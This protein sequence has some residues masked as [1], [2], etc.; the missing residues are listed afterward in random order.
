M[1]GQTALLSV[2]VMWIPTFGVINF[3]SWA[4]HEFETLPRLLRKFLKEFHK[5]EVCVHLTVADSTFDK[6]D[7]WTLSPHC[8]T[9][10]V[11]NSNE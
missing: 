6:C 11:S 9:E 10:A 3:G 2:A 7:L 8:G 5:T 1:Q 4:S